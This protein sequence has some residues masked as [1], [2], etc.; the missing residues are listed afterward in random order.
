MMVVS[1]WLGQK[2][3]RVPYAKKKMIAYL[4]IITLIYLLHRGLVGLYEPLWFSITSGM[5][6]YLLF[7]G[8]MVIV[9]R[10]AFAGLPVVGRF[11][12][13]AP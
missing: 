2:K 11:F 7:F 12:S 6:L 10:R 8:F 13:A 9:E 1:Y 4:V 5:V 3:F